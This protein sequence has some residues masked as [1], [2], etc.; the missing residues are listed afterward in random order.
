MIFLRLNSICAFVRKITTSFLSVFFCL[1]LYKTQG[2]IITTIASGTTIGDGNSALNAGF[3]GPTAVGFDQNGN[4]LIVDTDDLRIRKIDANG[5]VSTFAGT[6]E[7]GFAGDNGS[8]TSA[9]FNQPRGIAIDATG[10]VYVSDYQNNR[11]RRVNANGTITTIAGNGNQGFSGDGGPAVN[12]QVNLPQNLAIDGAGNLY[13]ADTQNHRIRKIGTD[14]IITTVAGNGTA[15]FGGDGGPATSGQLNSPAAVA[16]GTD[17]S[18]YIADTENYRVRKV[19]PT[20]F[21]TTLAGNGAYQSGGDGGPAVSATLARPL[22]IAVDGMGTVYIT[23]QDARIRKITPSGTMLPVAGNGTEGFS[24]DSGLAIN[25]LIGSET[26]VDVDAAGTVYIADRNNFRIRRITSDDVITTIAGGYSGDG[27]PATKAFFRKTIAKTPTNLA[28]DVYG[29]VYISDRFGNRIRKVT[30]AG[31]ISSVA[32]TGINGYAGDGGL[33]IEAQL[34]HPRGVGLD[35]IG[36][37]YMIDQYNRRIRKVDTNGQITTTAGDGRSEFIGT[38]PYV[39]SADIYNSNGMAVSKSGTVYVP[40]S[41]CILKITP[42]GVITIVAGTTAG[43]GYSGDGGPATSAQLGFYPRSVTLDKDENLYIV[44]GGNNRIRRVDRN[45]IITTVVGNGASGYGGENVLATNSPLGGPY[46]V[47]FDLEGAMYISEVTFNRI[48]KVD[49]N[50]IMTTVAGTAGF[51][52]SGDG[53]PALNARFAYPAGIKTDAAG[54]LYIADSDN[55]RIRKITYPVKA[56]V[57]ASGSVGC[58]PTSVTITAQP[59]G[60]GFAYQF[61]PGATQIGTS[62]QAVVTSAGTYS[63]TVTTSIFGSPAGTASVTVTESASTSVYTVKA[64]NW[65]DPTVWSCGTVPTAGQQARVLHVIDLP[66]NYQAQTRSIAYE[67]GGRL[68]LALGANLRLT[69]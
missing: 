8:A 28:V 11:I 18:L 41:N 31:I 39:T 51:G 27:G 43:T 55:R 15:G 19:G 24:G 36:N 26:G 48:R 6:G 9:L 32:G 46:G 21:I 58:S 67:V 5:I 54:N 62:N 56:I 20:G 30:P 22:D 16:V 2:Q 59:T 53:G 40:I 3:G 44:D 13:I 37:L 47:A 1:L 60:P 23:Q 17:G 52:F 61:G 68:R 64:G 50:G 66:A 34:R 42:S 65:N 10:V 29:N 69:Q 45:G 35:S 63:V 57:T 7:Y 4:M 33:A 38:W 49:R 14:G 25:A 12:A